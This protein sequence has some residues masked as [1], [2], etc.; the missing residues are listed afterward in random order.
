MSNKTKKDKESIK[1][2]EELEEKEDKEKR[3]RE[4]YEKM[5]KW[6]EN[7]GIP[8]IGSNDIDITGNIDG[9]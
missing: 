9:S 2:E 3:K 8:V 4:I 5:L 6:A 7:A 1:K